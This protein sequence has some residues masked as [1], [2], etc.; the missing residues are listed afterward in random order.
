[1]SAIQIHEGWMRGPRCVNL[2]TAAQQGIRNSC[3]HVLV[4]PPP[5]ST[6]QIYIFIYLLICCKTISFTETPC[7]IQSN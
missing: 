2:V 7:I 1:M 3:Y 5:R 6:P 4:Q